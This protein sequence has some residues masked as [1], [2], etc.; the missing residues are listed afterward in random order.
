MLTRIKLKNFRAF[1]EEV[2]IRIRPITVLI[3]RNSAGK[4][5]LIKFLLMLQ[6]TLEASEGEFFSTEGRHV[7]LGTFGDLK[8]SKFRSNNF[9]FSLEI[10]TNDLPEPIIQQIREDIK[11]GKVIEKLGSNIAELNVK[12]RTSA[13]VKTYEPL[14]E[15]NLKVSSTIPAEQLLAK[16]DISGSIP[17][18]K[19]T[20]ATHSIICKINKKEILKKQE[21]NIR[22]GRTRFLN[23]PLPNSPVEILKSAFDNLYLDGVKHELLAMRHLSPIREESERTVI[24]GSPPADDV[25]HRGE[26]AMPHLQKLLEE[27]GEKAEF[28]LKHIEAVVDIKDLNFKPRSKGFVPE[29]RAKNKLTGAEAYLADFGFGVSQCIPIFVQ[30]ALLNPGQLLIVEQPEAQIHPSSQLEMGSFFSDLWKIRKVPCLIETHSEN[31]ILRLRKLI[32]KGELEP[33]DVGVVYFHIEENKNQ[34]N[35][36]RVTNLDIDSKGV[37]QKGLPMSFFGADV[38]E[39]LGIRPG[40]QE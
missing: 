20:N 31:I 28:I 10:E 34:E 5:T 15:T 24:L 17:Y 7:S 1:S 3:G 21:A 19:A 39:A 33:E 40:I 27:D 29:F 2:D 14:K 9:Q 8:N 32:A 38:I 30:G 26:Y 11:Q 22:R 6:Q 37:L 23:F 36:V 18:G 12:L 13:T 25:G 35:V 16:F 4:S